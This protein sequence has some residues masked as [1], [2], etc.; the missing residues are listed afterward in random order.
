MVLV[1]NSRSGLTKRRVLLIALIIIVT[2]SFAGF[3]AYSAY[4][5]RDVGSVSVIVTIFGSLIAH[6]DAHG[7]LLITIQ[8]TARAPITRIIVSGNIL[9]E[10]ITNLSF[11]SNGTNMTVSANN[12]L[13]VHGV[14]TIDSSTIPVVQGDTYIMT[15]VM[16]FSN[17]S[18]QVQQLQVIATAH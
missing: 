16:D 8:N 7:V 18:D 3:A 10:N 15:V 4:P 1:N 13:P 2:C 6:D 11:V 17:G 12:P 9:S 5:T 14:A